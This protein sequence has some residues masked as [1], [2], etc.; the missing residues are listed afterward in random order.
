ML[1]LVGFLFES[2]ADWQ[3][4]QWNLTPANKHKF[5]NVGLWGISRHPN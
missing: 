4:L 2:I 1:W 5:I 3:K